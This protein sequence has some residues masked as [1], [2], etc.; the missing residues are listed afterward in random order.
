MRVGHSGAHLD[1]VKEGLCPYKP[2]IKI[3]TYNN[4]D[5]GD[6]LLGRLRRYKI[7]R[8]VHRHT[9]FFDMV[10]FFLLTS[11]KWCVHC[12]PCVPFAS[13]AGYRGTQ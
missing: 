3:I 2:I 13:D 7:L 6:T 8:S 9:H 12:G 10:I 11:T 4:K 1:T 5:T